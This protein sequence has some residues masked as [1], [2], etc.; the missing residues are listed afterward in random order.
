MVC[1]LGADEVLEYDSGDPLSRAEGPFDVIVDCVGGYSAAKCR[2][3]LGPGGRHVMVAG[4]SPLAM[5]QVVVPPF[6][7]RAILGR[8]NGERLHGLV[9]A[10]ADGL[11]KVQIAERMP[12]V[13][14]E[15]AHEKSKSGRMIGKLVLMAR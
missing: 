5:F 9:Q 2:S 3:L 10:V 11:V 13:D 6:R 12:L 8:P 1:E 15:A 7:S 14:A 4:D